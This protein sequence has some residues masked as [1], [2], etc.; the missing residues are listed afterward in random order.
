MTAGMHNVYKSSLVSSHVKAWRHEKDV[1][2][3]QIHERQ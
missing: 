1:P 3:S 2:I